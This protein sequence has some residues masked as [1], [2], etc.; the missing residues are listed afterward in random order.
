MS[1][2]SL[3]SSEYGLNQKPNLND[4]EISII[5]PSVPYHQQINGYYCGPAAL[6]MIM[7]Y[8]GPDIPQEEIAEV[9]RTYIEFGGTYTWELRR[10]AH[11][12]DLS[13]SNGLAIDGTIKGYSERKLGYISFDGNLNNASCLK[14]LIDCGYPLLVIT[15]SDPSHTAY[16]FRV[17]I[18]YTLNPDGSIRE[19]IL[20]DP[21]CGPNYIMPYEYFV[22]L[23]TSHV[24]WTLFVSPWIIN[25]SYPHEINKNES[26]LISANITYPCPKYF[27]NSEYIA[28]NCSATITLPTGFSL[29]QGENI[30]KTLNNGTLQGGNSFLVQWNVTANSVDGDKYL[31]IQAN[32]Q[33]NGSVR[34]YLIFEGY[35]Y[36]DKI[37]GIQTVLII[38]NGQFPINIIIMISSITIVGLSI[39][40]IIVILKRRR[41]KNKVE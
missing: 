39:G 35:S 1:Y 28:T 9:A 32:G 37:G 7:D 40:L 30:T 23:W 3:K 15:S 36:I 19:F 6:E 16:H 14:Y 20:N 34:A 26:F 10:A 38:S 5:I 2:K 11:F 29:S 33:I 4:D 17:I 24:N 12:S 21:W 22:D 13:Y 27:D 8:Y 25:I 31:T 18:G 41:I